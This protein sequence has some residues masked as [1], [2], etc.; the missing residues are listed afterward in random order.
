M[1]AL[2]GVHT[3]IYC[4]QNCLELGMSNRYTVSEV[5]LFVLYIFISLFHLIKCGR[6]TCTEPVLVL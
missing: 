1:K 6:H 5:F 2:E 4:K 3:R